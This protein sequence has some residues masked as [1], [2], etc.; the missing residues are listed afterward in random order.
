MVTFPPEKILDDIAGKS[1]LRK[2]GAGTQVDAAASSV[3]E[4]FVAGNRSFTAVQRAT[5]ND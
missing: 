4:Q 2:Y 1:Q 5:R 3:P